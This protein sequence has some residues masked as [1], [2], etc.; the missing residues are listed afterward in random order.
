MRNRYTQILSASGVLLLGEKF[1][2]ISQLVLDE[3]ETGM[4]GVR[5][6]YG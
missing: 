4:V 3:T 5:V 2:L 6:T 1:K